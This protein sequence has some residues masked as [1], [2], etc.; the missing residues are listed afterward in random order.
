MYQ[1]IAAALAA[2]VLCMPAYA[3]QT[4]NTMKM[5]SYFPVPYVAYDTVSANNAMDIGVLNQC[6]MD[7]KKGSSNLG[8]SAC[9]LYLYG[10][11]N[12]ADLNR[13][14]LNV[15]AGKLDL[16]STVNNARIVSKKV[17]IGENMTTQGGWLD[18]GMPAGKNDSYDALYL[19][20]IANTG[21]SFRVTSK[22]D[23]ATVNSFHMFNEISNDFPGCAGTVTWQE[24]ELGA[25]VDTNTTYTDVYLVCNGTGDVT[26]PQECQAPRG[27][28][29]T[30]SCP[31]GQTGTIT[32]TWVG[33]PTCSYKK[34]D[35]CQEEVCQPTKGQSYTEECPDGQTGTITYTWNQSACKYDKLE[36]CTSL[37]CDDFSYKMNHKSECCPS[38][39]YT[40][41]AC[42]YEC[43]KYQWTVNGSG[44]SGYPSIVFGSNWV[45]RAC[46]QG[47]QSY[48]VTCNSSVSGNCWNLKAIAP[49]NVTI[50]YSNHSLTDP[51][52][53]LTCSAK[54]EGEICLVVSNAPNDAGES[55]RCSYGPNKFSFYGNILGLKCQKDP[56]SYCKN[57]W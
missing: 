41:L 10:N 37:T 28:T 56:H 44:N 17:Q 34:T 18:I 4:K 15:T 21:N 52:L 7:I 51:C 54:N 19:G 8:G 55:V 29:Y 6:V 16:N 47:N 36:E 14:L 50:I 11:A 13:G 22:E 48:N 26:P 40:D 24:L 27:Q 38:A 25:D 32:Y 45:E 35:N 31:N 12:G 57:G 2:A 30:E 39:P 3:A 23:G 46:R 33:E 42:Y 9:S 1:K 53:Q 20:S 43:P 49:S 5:V